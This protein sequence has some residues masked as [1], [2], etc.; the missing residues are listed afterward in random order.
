MNLLGLP[1]HSACSA[2]LF[3]PGSVIYLTRTV[4][5][6]KYN[7]N[8]SYQICLKYSHR[9]G[10]SNFHWS[11]LRCSQNSDHHFCLTTLLWTRQICHSDNSSAN[12]SLR[13][14]SMLNLGPLCPLWVSVPISVPPSRPL[15]MNF[16]KSSSLLF[17]GLFALE[18]RTMTLIHQFLTLVA[19]W[20]DA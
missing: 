15:P 7:H 14:A 12:S 10:V 8:L 11:P 9:S 20:W 19:R 1:C 4:V 16:F 17:H 5:W 2:L 18:F 13:R 6:P 3:G